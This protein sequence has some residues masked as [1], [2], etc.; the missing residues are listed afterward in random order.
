M[1]LHNNK[2]IFR[3]AVIFA[4]QKFKLPQSYIEKDY[5]VTFALH[6]IFN[7]AISEQIVFKGGTSLSKCFGIVDRFSEDIDL[8][9]LRKENESGNQSR[10]KLKLV[11]R[12]VSE[13]LPEIHLDGITNKKGMIRKTAHSFVRLFEGD[14]GQIRN[15]IILEATW[16]GYYEPYTARKVSSMVYQALTK[17][18]DTTIVN[19]YGLEPFDVQVLEPVR[20]LCEKIMS[21]VRFSWSDDP[22]F[23]LRNKIRHT[24]DL[25]RMLIQPDIHE[26]FLSDEF[27]KML[28]RVAA[29]DVKSFR[30]NNIWLENHPRRAR[31]FSELESIWPKLRTSY[32]GNFRNLVYGEF[33]DETEIKKTL[34]QIKERLQLIGWDIHL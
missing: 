6:R 27:E 28:M 7:H 3:D 21:L 15:E 11:T 32:T 34:E 17:T 9:L 23:N 29:D 16:L 13:I 22:V 18:E 33:P 20:T 5:W 25:N 8:V 4:S 14:L 10:E 24:Y 30:N 2:E 26:F 1:N 31:I 12:L 19:S